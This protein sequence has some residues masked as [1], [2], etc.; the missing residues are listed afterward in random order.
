MQTPPPEQ[1]TNITPI[2]SN[3]YIPLSEF[4]MAELQQAWLEHQINPLREIQSRGVPF[5][6]LND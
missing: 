4:Q 5:S 3:S 6:A 1:P 2:I